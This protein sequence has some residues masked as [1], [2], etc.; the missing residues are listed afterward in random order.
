V[1]E[2]RT[3]GGR[4]HTAAV[5]SVC[6]AVLAPTLAYRLGVD[7]GVFAYMGAA[8]LE[9]RWP[10]V[11]TWESDYPGLVFIQAAEIA[12]L[13]KSVAAFRLFDIV[14]QLTSAWI[15]LRM[16]RHTSGWIGATIAPVLFC[17][18]YQGYGPWNTAQREGFGLPLIL[19]GFW[20]TFTAER[21]PPAI[22]AALA[23]LGMGMAVTIKPTLLALSLF[24]LPLAFAIRTP[25]ALRV[26]A[27]GLAGLILPSAVIVVGYWRAGVLGEMY[28]ACVAYQAIYTARLRGDGSVVAYWI[29]KLTSLGRNAVILPLAYAPFLLLAS[30]RRRERLMLWLAYIGAT[31]AVFVQG[32]FAGYHYLPGLAIGSIFVGSMIATM[33]TWV[34]TRLPALA[35]RLPVRVEVAVVLLVLVPATAAYMRRAPVARLASLQ[36]L[37]PPTPNEFRNLTL[38]D[39]TESYETAAYLRSRTR[40]DERIQ[41]WGYESLVYYLAE[42]NASSRFQMTHPLVMRVPGGDLTPMQK[43][44]RAEFV[45]D[46]TA[47]P[48]AYVA[49]VSEDRW[50]WAPEERSSQELLAD[51]PEWRAI[52]DTHYELE[53]QIGRFLIYRRARPTAARLTP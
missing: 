53:Q 46:L 26:V 5:L 19:I 27:A 20:L 1:I 28:D 49:V 2:T 17:L 13:G 33:T 22:T 4:W 40:P 12:L 34:A 8:L 44:W 14:V 42:R 24:Y 11:H 25:G 38:F 35:R 37:D 36:F 41:V 15:I 16:A 51:F 3:G 23:G 39:F 48:P 52:I 9:G 18:I 10:Y 43:N 21:R 50:W 32:T 45:A 29:R 30:E 7:Q 31:F 47:R 6:A